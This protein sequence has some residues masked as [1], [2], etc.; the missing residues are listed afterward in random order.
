[1]KRRIKIFV[2]GEVKGVFFRA[3]VKEEA[4]KLNIKGYVKNSDDY[5]EAVFEGN[6]DSINKMII[7]CKKGPK[8]SRVDDTK[9]VEEEFGNEFKKFEIVY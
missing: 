5:V 9:I 1:M 8:F 7:L 6:S 4:E 2:Y 3:F